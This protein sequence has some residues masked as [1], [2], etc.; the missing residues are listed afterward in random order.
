MFEFVKKRAFMLFVA[1]LV[2]AWPAV[3]TMIRIMTM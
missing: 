1:G 3:V 2:W